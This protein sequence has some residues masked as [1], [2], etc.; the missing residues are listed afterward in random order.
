MDGGRFGWFG[1][2]NIACAECDPTDSPVN[3]GMV[4]ISYIFYLS[5]FVEMMDTMFFI[6]RKKNH[7]LTSLHLIHHGMLP[8][9]C[10]FTVKYLPG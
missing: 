4:N 9:S 1:H 7:L 5:K 2:Y 6:L 3:R 8:V 10:W